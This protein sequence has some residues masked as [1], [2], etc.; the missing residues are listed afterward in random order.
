M[1][2]KIGMLGLTRDRSFEEEKLRKFSTLLCNTSTPQK[3]NALDFTE[4]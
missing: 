4:S 3:Q 1:S 2:S